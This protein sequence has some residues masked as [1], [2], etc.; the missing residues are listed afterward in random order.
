MTHEESSELR[1]LILSVVTGTS[2]FYCLDPDQYLENRS[3][4]VPT[5]W[6]YTYS[7]AFWIRMRNLYPRTGT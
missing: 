2:F 1:W 6:I 3:E 5:Y 4:F 7:T